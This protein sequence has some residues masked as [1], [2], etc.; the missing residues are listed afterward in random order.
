MTTTRASAV[1]GRQ[2][3]LSYGVVRETPIEIRKS[4]M[5]NPTQFPKKRP[6]E[7]RDDGDEY[8]D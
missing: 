7:E 5:F 1:V 2:G 4:R 6:V 8:E 3:H